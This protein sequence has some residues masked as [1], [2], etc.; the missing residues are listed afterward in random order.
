MQVASYTKN[1]MCVCGWRFAEV[2]RFLWN[3]N[4]YKHRCPTNLA[5]E[6]ADEYRIALIG[7][8]DLKRSNI[9]SHDWRIKI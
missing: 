2:D 3:P 5:V 7:F 4:S 9:Y 6:E 1:W 8:S